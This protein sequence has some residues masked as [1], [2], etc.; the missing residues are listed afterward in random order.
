MA[1]LHTFS[2]NVFISQIFQFVY[3]FVQHF[4]VLHQ[5]QSIL[6]FNFLSKSTIDLPPNHLIADSLWSY[7]AHLV[8]FECRGVPFIIAIKSGNTFLPSGLIDLGSSDLPIGC[9]RTYTDGRFVLQIHADDKG[10]TAVISNGWTNEKLSPPPPPPIGSW[11]NA[12]YFFTKVDTS[13]LLSMWNL[14]DSWLK[15]PKEK[16]IFHKLG[17]DPLRSEDAQGSNEVLTFAAAS[18]FNKA[19]RLAIHAQRFHLPRPATTKLSV[20]KLLHDLFPRSKEV[21]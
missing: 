2:S 19:Q 17:W 16:I 21:R 18:K 11:E 7:G 12:N 1:C 5:N 13:A 20:K 15:K 6:L 14:D 8:E 10:T 4:W 9:T 3:V